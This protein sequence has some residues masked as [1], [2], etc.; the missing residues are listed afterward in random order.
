MNEHLRRRYVKDLVGDLEL[1]GSG[2]FEQWIKPLWDSIAGGLVE[3]RGLNLEGAPVAGDYDARWPDGSAS[4]A[5]SELRYFE[6]PFEKAQND[7]GHVRTVAPQV[8]KIRLFCT[9]VAKQGAVDRLRRAVAERH[10]GGFELEVWDSRGIAEYIVD[11]LLRDETYVARVGNVLP[12]LKRIAEQ[13]AAT[14][15]VPP[16]S[17]AYGGRESEEAEVKQRLE[18]SK[19]VVLWGL[20]GVGKSQVAVATANALRD[21]YD[22]VMWVTAAEIE[23]VRDL[24]SV[25]VRNNGYA[26]NVRGSLKQHRVLLVLDDVRVDLDVEELAADCDVSRVIVT[27]QTAFGVEPLRIGFVDGE[28]AGRILSS[29]LERPCPDTI[30]DRA[31]ALFGGHPLVLELVNRQAVSD[32]DWRTVERDFEHLLGDTTQN[33]ETAAKRLLGRHVSAVGPELAFFDWCGGA[34][35]DAGLFGRRFGSRAREK[36][37]ERAMTVPTQDD[38]VQLH[39]LVLAALGRLRDEG[40]LR[41]DGARFES[42]LAEYLTETGYPKGLPFYRVVHRHRE[43]I[44]KL[45]QA[46]PR[47]GALRYAYIHGHRLGELRRDL[48]G[49]PESEVEAV[50]AGGCETMAVLSLMETIELDYRVARERDTTAAEAALRERLPLYDGVAERADNSGIRDIVRHHRAKTLVKLGNRKEALEEFCALVESTEVRFQARL[51]VARLSHEDPQRAL[52]MIVSIIE[53]ERQDPG[54][55]AT[56]VLLE[57]FATFRLGFLRERSKLFERKYRGFMAQQIKAAACSGESQPMQ[58]FAA[59]GADW[60]F[61]D[62]TLFIEVMEAIDIRNPEDAEDDRDRIAIGRVLAA[63]GKMYLRQDRRAEG[64]LRLEQAVEFYRAVSRPQAFASTHHADALIQLDRVDEALGVLETVPEAERESYWRL[65]R[66]EVH[67]AKREHPEALACLDLALQDTSLGG[68]SATFFE[69]RGD[70]LYDMR[71]L[72]F[73]DWFARAIEASDSE[74]N[75]TRLVGRLRAMAREAARW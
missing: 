35:V 5:S 39:Q 17:A 75:T 15:I 30:V 22:L 74:R 61:A 38:V 63:A 23:S 24:E 66:S 37:A 4:E 18:T 55:V 48:L 46:K 13:N 54:K 9:R 57:A 25:D 58:T 70:V 36:L 31:V 71:D 33:R 52:D 59:V 14:G 34:G 64:K 10:G 53:A 8:K 16:Q 32:G 49:T 51:Q 2:G 43:L 19:C 3:A 72:G 29:G 12:N 20:S 62:E 11:V 50:Q 65:R 69:S 42:G 40:V 68:R 28:H 60:A 41:V 56:S 6:A 73:R 67:R 44:R 1:V 7:V 21:R 45:L 26:L 27:S 47:P